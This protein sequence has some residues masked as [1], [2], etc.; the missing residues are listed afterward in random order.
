MYWSARGSTYVAHRA[1]DFLVSGD[2]NFRPI[3]LR[4]APNGEIYVIDWHD[5]NPCSQADPDSWDYTHGGGVYRIQKKG[6]VTKKAEDLGKKSTRQL[7]E[8]F[9]SGNPYFYRTCARGC[10]TECRE[11]YSRKLLDEAGDL[12]SAVNRHEEPLKSQL[13]LR[14]HWMMAAIESGHL[15]REL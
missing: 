9:E 2:K 3:N 10:F 4:R 5:Q 13:Q 12:W 14:H 7:M 1:D 15:S 6:A 8:V 11:P